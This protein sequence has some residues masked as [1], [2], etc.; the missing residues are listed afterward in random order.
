MQQEL[1]ATMQPMLQ[2]GLLVHGDFPFLNPM[3]PS[4]NR[5]RLFELLDAAGASSKYAPKCK[6]LNF[7]TLECK[8]INFC[9]LECKKINFSHIGLQWASF[10]VYI[11]RLV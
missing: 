1:Q 6:K 7:C 3:F 5:N 8:K 11:N 4:N 2:K 10:L 9:T